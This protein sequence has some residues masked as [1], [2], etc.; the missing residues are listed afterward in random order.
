MAGRPSASTRTRIATDSVT[1]FSEMIAGP[2][3]QYTCPPGEAYN[4]IESA[5]KG[6]PTNSG[7]IR[8]AT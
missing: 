6:A 3:C 4:S 7:T 2:N 1:E 5:A 8:S